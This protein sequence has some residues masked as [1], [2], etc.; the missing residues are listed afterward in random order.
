M[1]RR[2]KPRR[3][4]TLHRGWPGASKPL[5]PGTAQDRQPGL[6]AGWRVDSLCLESERAIL[7]CGRSLPEQENRA[8]SRTIRGT[9]GIRR[10][11]PTEN[12]SSGVS[13]R[14]G[15]HE[16]RRADA[17]GVGPRQ[18]THDGFGAENPG[19]TTDGWIYYVSGNSATASCG[20]VSSQPIAGAQYSRRHDVA[21]PASAERS[22]PKPERRWAELDLQCD[23]AGAERRHRAWPVASEGRSP[24]RQQRGASFRPSTRHLMSRRGPHLRMASG[25]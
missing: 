15:A 1:I 4:P 3:S 14:S 12:R 23:H 24:R 10:L 17:D 16:I 6:F 19:V 22:Q 8:A 25:S 13:D 20:P 11:L 21:S 9:T 18:I 5:T 7:I 2:G